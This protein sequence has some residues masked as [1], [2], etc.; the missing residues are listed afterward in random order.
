M[1]FLPIEVEEGET[2]TTLSSAECSEPAVPSRRRLVPDVDEDSHELRTAAWVYRGQ[3]S[4]VCDSAVASC[5]GPTGS[6][7]EMS[8][9]SLDAQS[10]STSDM[11]NETSSES[12]KKK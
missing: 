4:P 5:V 1:N 11:S 12:S 7:G 3:D 6:S 10:S 8:I 2:N 9:H